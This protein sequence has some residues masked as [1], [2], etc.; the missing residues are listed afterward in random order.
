MIGRSLFV[1]GDEGTGL[2]TTTAMTNVTDT[3]L[4]SGALSI[5]S[6]TANPGNNAG[7][8][9]FYVGTNVVW[10]PYFTNIAP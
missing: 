1:D 3:N 10:V 5:K 8:L 6:T 7:F 9:K 2:A 4:S